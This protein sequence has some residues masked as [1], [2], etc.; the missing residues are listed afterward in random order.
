M[1]RRS[2]AMTRSYDK[3]LLQDGEGYTLVELMVTLLVTMV[4]G[5]VLFSVYLAT[6]RYVEPWRREIKLEDQVHLIVQ[7]LTA[8]L[9]YAEQLIDQQNGTWTLTY[10]SGRI[11][12]YSYLDSVLTRNSHQMHDASLPVVDFR[13]VPSRLETQYALRRRDSVVDD[14]RSL[15]QVQIH[16][17]LQTRERTLATST[18][19]A[20]RRHRPWYPLP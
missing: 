3:A 12:H 1:T 7:R 14:E 5:G 4:L 2:N 15:I 20:L 11:V 9:T 10:P 13:L 19:A 16:L 6:T 18:T 8:D 17:D